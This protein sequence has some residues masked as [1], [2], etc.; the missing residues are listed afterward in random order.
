[1]LCN[2]LAL[3]DVSCWHTAERCVFVYVCVLELHHHH[4]DDCCSSFLTNTD[5]HKQVKS[6]DKM[7]YKT[8]VK[9]DKKCYSPS[10]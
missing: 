9:Q 8:T 6:C 10:H 5:M 4:H 3:G 7:N 1:M 2:Y